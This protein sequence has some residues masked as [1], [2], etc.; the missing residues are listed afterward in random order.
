[1]AAMRALLRA[2]WGGVEVSTRARRVT[3]DTPDLGETLATLYARG[4]A[5]HPRLRVGEEA[6]GRRVAR[7]LDAHRAPPLDRLPAE[8]LYLACACVEGVRGAASVFEAAYGD[9]IRKAVS[10]VATS[11]ADRD[12]A[13][14]IAR[15][16]LLVRGKND[17][18][19]GLA[20]Y[21]G[22]SSL[23]DFVRV[24]AL[25]TTISLGRAESAERR[26]RDKT[27]AEVVGASAEQLLMKEEIRRELAV[28]VAS[29][30]GALAPRDRLV[31]RL[32]LVSGMSHRAIARTLDVSHQAVSKQLAKVR[33]AVLEDVRSVLAA[34][35][36]ISRDD[37]ASF[38][39]FAAS[40]L[41]V[42]ISRVLG[43]R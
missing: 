22:Q 7:A 38:M 13:A 8:D 12:E 17:G 1:M 20:N 18:G 16:R 15:Q 36:D 24:V 40:Q 3:Y 42:S 4:R 33:E 10:R 26:L 25:R 5:A 37:V 9:A 30:L 27:A 6:F 11:P 31:L 2:F 21:H 28:A 35:L 39:R 23:A 14:Q 34:R 19:P 41:D 29:A 43:A 32:F